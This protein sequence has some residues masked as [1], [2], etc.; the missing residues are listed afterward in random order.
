MPE[1]VGVRFREAGK[2]YYFDGS[3]HELPVGTYVV[4]ETSHGEEVG[5]VVVSPDQ[6]LSSEIRE[7]LKPV[8]R[9]AEGEDLEKAESHRA[10]ALE[11]MPLVRDK[12]IEHELPMRIVGADYNLEG[13]QLTV[14]FTAEDRVDFR[15]LV[16]DLSSTLHTHLQMLQ[17]GDRDRARMV[18]GIGRCG[19]RLCCSSWLAG[20]PSISIKMAKE[21]DLP[22]NPAKISGACGRLLC[23]LVFEH[24]QYRALRGQLPKVGQVVS[25]PAG[26][27][28]V[29]GLNVL[30]QTVTLRLEEGFSIL[31]MPADELR[32]QYGT[33]VRPVDAPE[34]GAETLAK[35]GRAPAPSASGPATG[36]EPAA[37]ERSG[38]RRRRRRRRGRRGGRAT[39]VAEGGPEGTSTVQA[40]T[41]SPR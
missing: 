28:K 26:V 29:A 22:L 27:A 11:E 32:L 40:A 41:D 1:I 15:G 25:T 33:A 8:I 39:G 5:R 4:V 31:E 36:E 17:V 9:V 10:K 14:Y 20:F 37:G 6:I 21:Q 30:K 2:V 19:E 16:R 24:E 35:G 13:S 18:D 38:Q 3:G 12:V 7:P 23:C 34:A